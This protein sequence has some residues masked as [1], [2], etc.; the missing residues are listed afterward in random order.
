MY[1][2]KIYLK[3]FLI[4]IF[5]NSTLNAKIDSINYSNS[6]DLLIMQALEYQD[7]NPIKSIDIYEKLYND[8]KKSEYLEEVMR[9]AYAN[10]TNLLKRIVA[11]HQKELDSIKDSKVLFYYIAYLVDSKQTT[12]AK[13]VAKNL[14]EIDKS[15]KSYAVLATILNIEMDFEGAYQ[16]Y[17]MAYELDNSDANLLNLVRSMIKL[18]KVGEA[19][20]LLEELKSKNSPTFAVCQLLTEIYKNL[21]DSQKLVDNYEDLYNITKDEKYLALATGQLVKSGEI[22]KAANLMYKHKFGLEVVVE[23]Y[24]S[25]GDRKMAYSVA[26][27]AYMESKKP[28]FLSYMAIFEF[29]ESY[30][31]IDKKTLNSVLDKFK[32]SVKE[33]NEAL[34]YNY[35]G[36]LLIDYDVDIKKG[37]EF[38]EMALEK[39]EFNPAYIDSLAWGYYKLGDCNMAYDVLNTI[40][41]DDIKAN[42]E[43]DKHFETIRKC[44][45]SKK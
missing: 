5:L 33:S 42:K 17:K 6:D 44:L 9:L 4:A 35:Y 26:K 27:E 24:D 16:N 19:R 10:D 15:S 40:S 31:N 13:K 30:P 34:F 18:K 12:K 8:T 21:P 39:D 23:M 36:Y 2:R 11:S 20:E 22:L 3:S 41:R 1:R 32:N 25:L 29:E 7:S 43:I 38:V 37:I 28:Y 45:K 14:I